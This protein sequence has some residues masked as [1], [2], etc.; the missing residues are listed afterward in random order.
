M[1]FSLCLVY[2]VSAEIV[3]YEAYVFYVRT[4]MEFLFIASME[5][6]KVKIHP[7]L[8]LLVFQYFPFPP[9]RQYNKHQPIFHKKGLINYVF[10]RKWA[11]RNPAWNR[12]YTYSLVNK[13]VDR[14]G[15]LILDP[16]PTSF[17]TLSRK[18]TCDGLR[19]YYTMYR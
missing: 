8:I 3:N 10:C 17:T 6:K 19:P 11:I 4:K 1:Y 13:Q 9:K 12:P 5:K 15:P 16:P 2:L 14:A 18:E 7:F